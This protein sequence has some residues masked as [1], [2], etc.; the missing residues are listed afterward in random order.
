MHLR[1]LR[2]VVHHDLKACLQVGGLVRAALPFVTHARRQ[3]PQERVAVVRL[4]RARRHQQVLAIG[5][6]LLHAR[7]EGVQV[8]AVD[9]EGHGGVARGLPPGQVGWGLHNREAGGGAALREAPQQ[10]GLHVELR[11]HN[12]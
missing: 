11:L 10:R 7:L 9:A 5:E 6:V 12:F 8:G 4:Q 3:P 2:C 1:H